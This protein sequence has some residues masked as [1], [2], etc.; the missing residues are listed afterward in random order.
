MVNVQRIIG[1]S[2]A[3]PQR[4]MVTLFVCLL[5]YYTVYGSLASTRRRFL[6][7]GSN[8]KDRQCP[9]RRKISKTPSAPIPTKNKV[10]TRCHIGEKICYSIVSLLEKISLC[11]RRERAI[12][13]A[14]C[15]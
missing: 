9:R 13:R 2:M 3:S 8:R 7:N 1:C 4:A 12:D 15:T 5:T 11:K 10:I 6:S 14:L